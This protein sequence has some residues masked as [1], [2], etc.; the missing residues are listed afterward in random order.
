MSRETGPFLMQPARNESEAGN[1]VYRVF[2][3]VPE[4]I[5]RTKWGDFAVAI[6]DKRGR[7]HVRIIEAE[8]GPDSDIDYRN[9][10]QKRRVFA[11]VSEPGPKGGRRNEF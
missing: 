9:F 7:P 6:K 3:E 1:A 8:R 10:R 4:R 2:G 11:R 5:E